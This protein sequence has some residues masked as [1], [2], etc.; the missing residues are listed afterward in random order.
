MRVPHKRAQF[1]MQFR[2]PRFCWPIIGAS[3]AAY[4]RG[5]MARI[6]NF[7]SASPRLSFKTDSSNRSAMIHARHR[8]SR[9]IYFATKRCV[10]LLKFTPRADRESD[11]SNIRTGSWITLTVLITVTKRQ[12]KRAI[13]SAI[14]RKR[15]DRDNE[16]LN[17]KS[18]RLQCCFS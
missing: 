18:R 1:S 13:S 6:R 9:P 2:G 17:P 14:F 16:R 15:A 8:R 12:R 11:S 3:Y 4:L 10:F 7:N 5:P